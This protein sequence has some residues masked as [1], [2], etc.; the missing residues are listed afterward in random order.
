MPVQITESTRVYPDLGPRREDF[1][2]QVKREMA[3]RGKAVDPLLLTYSDFYN[4]I[5]VQITADNAALRYGYKIEIPDTC[6]IVGIVGFV[7][8]LPVGVVVGVLWFLKYQE[9]EKAL[10]ESG[11]AAAVM[12]GG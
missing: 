7:A 8:C 9:F 10:K 5:S 2:T 12:L 1:V 3:V 6:L 11:D 4:N